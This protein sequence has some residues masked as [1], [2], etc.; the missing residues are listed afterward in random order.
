MFLNIIIFS[1]FIVSACGESNGKEMSISHLKVSNQNFRYFTDTNGRSVYLTGSHT[2][3]NFKDMGSTDPPPVFDFEG[4]LKML[5]K[6]NHNFIRLWTWELTK[7]QYKGKPVKYSTPFPWKRTGPGYALDGKPK[8]DLNKFDQSYFDRL[9]ERIIAAG[10]RGIYVS[11]M[12]FEGHGIF[13]SNS[14]WRWDGHP[15]NKNNNINGI[16]GDPNKDGIGIESHTLKIPEIVKIQEEY[17]KKVVDTVNDLDNVLYEISNEDH[18]ESIEWQYHFINFIKNYEK[19]KPKQHPV[20]MTTH[21]RLGN[22]AV[23][24]SPA[25][26]ISPAVSEW[27]K[28]DPYKDDPPIS[29]VKKVII[30]DTDHLWGIGGDRKWVWKSFLRGYNPIYMDDMSPHREDVRMAMGQTITFAR[31]INLSKMYPSKDISSTGYCLANPGS[32]YLIYQPD[33]GKSFKLNIKAGSYKYEWFNP[34]KGVVTSGNIIVDSDK[35]IYVTPP[36]EDD[37]VLYISG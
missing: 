26:W 34:V 1:L 4:Y 21:S 30:L 3:S 29:G 15:F 2:W 17:V 16:D 12:L 18:A 6:Y 35:S 31:R 7:F 20:G 37:A 24:N 27:S 22:D 11:I 28:D 19:T 9:R 33:S 23:F 8:F 13:F 5:R 10:E 36:F 25:D 14:P 32:E